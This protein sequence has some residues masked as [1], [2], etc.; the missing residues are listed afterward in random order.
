MNI[1]E[2][3]KV[4]WNHRAEHHA[5]FWIATENYQTEETFHESGEVTAQALLQTLG[6]RYDPTWRVLDIGCGIGRVLKPL[7]SFFQHLIGVDVSSAMINQSKTWLANQPH[8]QTFETS[9]QD[10]QEFPDQHFDLV[11]SYVAFQHMPRPVLER[12]LEEINRVL[13]INGYLV[14]QLPIGRHIDCPLE[15]TIGIRSY[16]FKE[17]EDKLNR[18][19]LIFL[20]PSFTEDSTSNINNQWDHRFCL[21]QKFVHTTPT[22][23]EHCEDLQRLLQ[24]PNYLSPL[25]SQLLAKYAIDCSQTGQASEAI[26]TLQTHITRDPHH[27]LG[28][29]QLIALLFETEQIQLALLTMRDMIRI[30]PDYQEGKRIFQQ[31][32]R[33]CAHLNPALLHPTSKSDLN[34]KNIHTTGLI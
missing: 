20:S 31:F 8:I 33:K 30:H 9:G 24:H 27:L 13:T 34:H 25:D 21:T 26:R 4:D 23:S 3:M 15:D 18:N 32:L 29:L 5:R 10:L 1:K 12:Y 7:A 11:Y 14:F 2:K 22:H 6:N 19:G 28:W 17:I 16:P